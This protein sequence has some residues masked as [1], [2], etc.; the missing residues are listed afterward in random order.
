MDSEKYVFECKND[1]VAVVGF[2]SQS[3]S[4][5]PWNN[6]KIDLAGLN[7][8]LAWGEWFGNKDPNMR[9]WKAPEEN[10]SLW[11]QLHNHATFSRSENHNDPQHYEWLK[12]KHPF[13]IFMQE[14][15]PDV[16]SSVKFPVEDIQKEFRTPDGKIYFT[17]SISYIMCHLYMLGYKRIEVYGF[18]MASNTEYAFQRPN[19]SWIAGRLRARGI[20]IYV[21]PMSNFLAGKLYAFEDNWVGWN[22]D[23]EINR[24]KI[25]NEQHKLNATID[26][27]RGV[28]AALI[29]TVTK[30][31]QT[32]NEIKEMA[33]K[34]AEDIGEMEKKSHVITGRYD[35]LNFASK[36]HEAFRNIGA[37]EEL[38]AE[39]IEGQ[40][41]KIADEKEVKA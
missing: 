28:Y 20:D 21:P 37:G 8:E 17:S 18:E 35:G 29:D 7:E 34:V 5:T 10:V 33:E 26:K 15:Y 2:A 41:I 1:T 22:Q 27:K 23:M 14:K 32:A 39:T 31:T 12:Q 4:Y 13:P 6:P 3:R 30:H 9:W 19:A 40:P 24:T 25:V 11:Y 16:P 38:E 36:L